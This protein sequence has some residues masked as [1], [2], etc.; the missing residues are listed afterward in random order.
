MSNLLLIIM[1]IPV[2]GAIVL[3]LMKNSD[4]TR[5]FAN[6]A[7]LFSA[8]AFAGTV[9]MM[10]SFIP[11][12]GFQQVFNYNWIP[13]LGVTF[14]GGIDGISLL[15]LL[16][17]NLL[18]PI[19]IYSSVGN[20]IKNAR[21][22][23]ALILF[24]QFALMG[25]FVALDGFLFYIFW[26]LALIP[27]WFI[28][29]LWGGKDSTRITLKFFIY[30][31][32]GS[33][34]MLVGFIYLYL[35]TPGTHSFSWD[36]LHNLPLTDKQQTFVFWM[37][38][39]S[40]GIKMPVWPLHT[41]QPDTYTDAPTQGTMLLSGIMLK[42]GIYGVIRWMLPTVPLAFSQW[43]TTVMVLAIIGIVYASCMALVQ[44]DY[45]RLIA[46]SSIAHVGLIAAGI[47]TLNNQGVEGAVIQMFAHGIN[48]VGLFMIVDILQK[49]FHT[50]NIKELGG[51]ANSQSL[52]S[53][54]FVI[55]M[56]GTVALPLTNGFVGE[57]LLL[58][59]VFQYSAVMAAFA[60]LTVIL[61]AVYML[62]S[63]QTIM[64]GGPT[65]ATNN[66]APLRLQEKVILICISFIVIVTGLF[67]GWMINMV[68]PSVNSMLGR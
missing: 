47:F 23:Y 14:Y 5:T 48:V 38:F 51:I 4:N 1:C 52:F 44:K 59:G 46:Y 53:I 10:L 60:G 37:M 34:F 25:V 58:S 41:W 57:F 2:I 9:A 30:T 11:A 56:L 63:Y 39:L 68:E 17:T 21:A 55:I 40:F 61:G 33:L 18:T 8:A 36:A 62:R 35:Q 49:R 26:E 7:L 45:K 66:F 67:P 16:L 42:M 3:S 31:L 50:S 6:I 19:I 32:T 12:N 22:F 64:L 43:G 65:S 54:L 13:G 28:C 24:M 15:L 27:I 29:L 20:Q